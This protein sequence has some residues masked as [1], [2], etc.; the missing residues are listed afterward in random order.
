[1]IHSVES[2]KT[3]RDSKSKVTAMAAWALTSTWIYHTNIHL[4]IL[5][6]GLLRSKWFVQM[7]W[8]CQ[9]YYPTN[10]LASRKSSHSSEISMTCSLE[11]RRALRGF[12]VLRVSWVSWV[13]LQLKRNSL[14]WSRWF[15]Q[16]R[17]FHLSFINIIISCHRIACSC[18]R[19]AFQWEGANSVSSHCLPL[20][21]QQQLL[22]TTR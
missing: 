9:D 2:T 12:A 18:Q 10:T 3:R 4:R 11:W 7:H 20:V 14:C 21:L 16:V 15:V 13:V 6:W 8:Y 17:R 19:F 22:L 1:M 5:L